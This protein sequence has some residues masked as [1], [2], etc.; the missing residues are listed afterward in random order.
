MLCFGPTEILTKLL[1]IF[2]DSG[3]NSELF[4]QSIQNEDVCFSVASVVEVQANGTQVWEFPI[5]VGHKLFFA[6]S[7]GVLSGQPTI[8][9]SPDNNG[10]SPW[11]GQELHRALDVTDL[12]KVWDDGGSTGK[13]SINAAVS[14]ADYV[15]VFLFDHFPKGDEF[16]EEEGTLLDGYEIGICGSYQ[17][18]DDGIFT[19][20]EWQRHPYD[21][22]DQFT[23]NECMFCKGR[24]NDQIVRLCL[25]RLGAPCNTAFNTPAREAFCNLEFECPASTLSFSL[26]LIFSFLGALFYV[27]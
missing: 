13:V 24:A 8:L 18:G 16:V 17:K 9:L 14:A 25:E 22:T 12:I 2:V 4:E 1:L 3:D 21:C 6:S 19:E 5:A 26:F 7:A 20:H 27:A 10:L 15:N 11:N 23:G